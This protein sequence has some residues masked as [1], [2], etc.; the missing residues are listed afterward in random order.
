MSRM[1][2]EPI[3][4]IYIWFIVTSDAMLNVDSEFDVDENSD[5]KC[6]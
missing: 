3:L 2:S 4:C 1:A 6:K 5:V